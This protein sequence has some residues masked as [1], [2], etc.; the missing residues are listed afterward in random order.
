MEDRIKNDRSYFGG[1]NSLFRRDYLEDA[2]GINR[3]YHWGEDFE[4]AKR[5]KEHGCQTVYHRDPIYHDT[6]RNFN[7]FATTQFVGANSFSESGFEATGMGVTMHAYEQ[8]VLG[9][10]GM[11]LGLM[12]GEHSWALF[13]IYMMI[14]ATA[15]SRVLVSPY[16][17]E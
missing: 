8:F 7:E 10:Y 4:W 5:L 9:T 12:R 15:Y 11:I 14:R 2:G 6:M 13:P 1:G 17:G 3:D 16:Y